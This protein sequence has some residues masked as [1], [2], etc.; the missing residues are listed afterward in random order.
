MST[1]AVTAALAAARQASDHPGGVFARVSTLRTMRPEKR[2]QVARLTSHRQRRVVPASRARSRR[3]LQ[4]RTGQ[5]RHLAR[6]AVDAQAMRQVGRELEREQSVSSRS[7]GARGCRRPGASSARIEQAAVVVGEPSSRAEH[8]MPGS[9]RRAACR[10]LISKGVC[11]RRRPGSLRRP[12][13]QGTGCPGAR[14]RAADDLQR[15]PG[16]ASTWQTRRRSAF[17]CCVADD[18]RHHHAG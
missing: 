10:G 3:R 6:D 2:P 18:L 14:W 9:R 15:V 8:S 11:R 5:R 12:A 13:A 16:P 17:G 7:T 1:S 4:R